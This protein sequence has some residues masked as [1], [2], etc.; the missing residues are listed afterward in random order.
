VSF[1]GTTG[2]VLLDS[3]ISA[4][5]V[6]LTVIKA[7]DE[8]NVRD[9][10]AAGDGSSSHAAF[11][12]AVNDAYAKPYGGI[13]KVPSGL[14]Q[15]GSTVQFPKSSSKRVTFD[16]APDAI[17]INAPG[18]TSPMFYI[19]S[20]SVAVGGC[21]VR[22]I[23]GAFMGN[24]LVGSRAFRLENANLA[25][26]ES[27][28]FIN[29]FQAIDMRLSYA[30]TLFNCLFD[31]AQFYSIYSSTSCHH[32][33]ILAC[34]F[35][36]TGLGNTYTVLL[37]GTASDNIV[38]DACSFETGWCAFGAQAGVN[39]FSM[40]RCYLEYLSNTPFFFNGSTS[41][42]IRANWIALSGNLSLQNIA[43]GNF[44]FNT[45]F[46]QTV[47]KGNAANIEIR[48]NRNAGTGTWPAD[49]VEFAGTSGALLPRLTTAQR[50]AIASP[51]N[52]LVIYNTTTNT[53][54][55]RAGGAWV[56]F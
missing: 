45:G 52:G 16:L 47:V 28:Q 48:G 36:N 32:L 22:V 31:T 17:V 33:R 41:A 6:N 10:G 55:G 42:S 12:A 30:V 19:G 50:D 25:K 46:N 23:G 11:Q 26:F 35:F 53:F 37:D 14:Y 3:G 5:E 2:Q 24:D 38:I 1:S 54:Q 7:R 8:V 34:N 20:P 15:I 27:S 29:L 18:F 49:E 4:A 9:K 56:N 40:E 13:V 44:S 43:G 21:N 51:A 39:S